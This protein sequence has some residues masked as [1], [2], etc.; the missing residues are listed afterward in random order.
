MPTVTKFFPMMLKQIVR[1]RHLAVW[2]LLSGPLSI[3]QV[4]GFPFLCKA[5]PEGSLL[6]LLS[7]FLSPH[8]TFFPNNFHFRSQTGLQ[9]NPI[10]YS[11]SFEASN[12]QETKSA[13]PFHCLSSNLCMKLEATI[14]FT[15]CTFHAYC[16]LPY[17]GRFPLDREPVSV[18]C[19][20]YL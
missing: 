11:T 19:L 12:H 10:L 17:M 5:G 7:H 8:W 14:E 3:C 4:M 20:Y 6:F 18:T 16:T 13:P 9:Y 1:R 2:F 15:T